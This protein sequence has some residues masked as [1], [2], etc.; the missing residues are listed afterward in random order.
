MAKL[1]VLA[2]LA[3]LC[4]VTRQAAGYGYGSGYPAPGNGYPPP[5]PS[6]A[7]SANGLAI[8]FYGK[9]CPNAEK[10]VRGVVETEVKNNP[11]IG[12]G[13]IRM[14]FHDCFVEVR[15]AGVTPVRFGAAEP[16]R[17]GFA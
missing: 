8:G 7:P 12:A 13:L 6:S 16:S 11:G 2:L 3:V 17:S 10:I 5:T 1:A 4:S 15:S 9:T 14:L